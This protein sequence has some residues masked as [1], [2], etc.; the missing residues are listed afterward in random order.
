MHPARMAPSDVGAITMDGTQCPGVPMTYHGGVVVHDAKIHPVYWAPSPTTAFVQGQTQSDFDWAIR[1]FVGDMTSFPMF[2]TMAEYPDASGRAPTSATYVAGPLYT[3]PL[4]HTGSTTDPLNTA[5]IES[6]IDAFAAG[7]TTTTDDI[8]VLFTPVGVNFCATPSACTFA[9]PPGTGYL[10]GWHDS[11]PGGRVYAVV[12]SV[13]SLPPAG[14]VPRVPFPPNGVALDSTLNV[15]S[16]ELFETFTDPALNG[17]WFGPDSDDERCYENGDRC[18]GVGISFTAPLSGR[19]YDIQQEWSN[20]SA[21]CGQT[22][23]IISSVSPNSGPK[24]PTT[25]VTITG[26]GFILGST[27]FD[28]LTGVTCTSTTSCTGYTIDDTAGVAGPVHLAATVNGI[29]SVPTTKDVFTLDAT[30]SCTSTMTCDSAGYYVLPTL[31]LSCDTPVDI[32]QGGVKLESGVSTFSTSTGLYASDVLACDPAFGTR[33]CTAF[34]DVS[35]YGTCGAMTPP[36]PPP[37]TCG[38]VRHPHTVC[39]AG[40]VWNCCDP[41]WICGPP[42]LLCP[43]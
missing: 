10:G 31:N 43:R 26:S 16:H 12:A 24:G 25:L 33:S 6:A 37:P 17:G 21:G 8:F 35:H 11:T 7:M 18:T 13:N 19:S 29:R 22:N 41:T 32:Y 30:P 4:P 42:H 1:F 34:G 3:A 36:P 40:N 38:G 5:D 23:A 9:T 39:D 15:L 2:A 14:F 27:S 20:A 28:F